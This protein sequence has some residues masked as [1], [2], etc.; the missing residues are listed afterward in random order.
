MPYKEVGVEYYR[1]IVRRYED[2]Y[3]IPSSQFYRLLRQGIRTIDN[4]VH[5]G[6]W[7]SVYECLLE[8]QDESRSHDGQ[9][10]DLTGGPT[11][12]PVLVVI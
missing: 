5:E 7:M 8:W 4:L 1:Q 3:G 9:A 12:P 2:A 11:R 10:Y 6:D